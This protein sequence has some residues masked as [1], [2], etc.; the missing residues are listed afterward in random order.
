MKIETAVVIAKGLCY[1]V[2]GGLTPLGTSLGQWVNSGQWPPRISWVMIVAG[3]CVGGATQLLSYL[4]G[5]YSDYLATKKANG[6]T[7][8][9]KKP[10]PTPTAQAPA[11]PQTIPTIK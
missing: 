9:W 5:S 8:F 11:G 7:E 1:V 4:S 10:V 2:I 3:C 6:G